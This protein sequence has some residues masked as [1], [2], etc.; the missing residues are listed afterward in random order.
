MHDE[1]VNRINDTL[2]IEARIREAIREKV[3]N[4]RVITQSTM[5][6]HAQNTED[7]SRKWFTML[8]QHGY[9]TATHEKHLSI[10]Y[11]KFCGLTF[12]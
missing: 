3:K 4:K 8:A 10:D 5:H 12:R 9:Y 11:M 7:L 2:A 6:N 1:A